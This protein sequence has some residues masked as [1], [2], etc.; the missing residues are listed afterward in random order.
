MNG[1]NKPT[2]AEQ[3][4]TEETPEPLPPPPPTF[5][6][7]TTAEPAGG[8]EEGFP[9]VY[10]SV[11][12]R[13]NPWVVYNQAEDD[14]INHEFWIGMQLTVLPPTPVEGG[15]GAEAPAQQPALTPEQRAL[16]STGSRRVLGT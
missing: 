1:E 7:R 15:A 9:R 5:G 2:Q 11:Y 16:R 4:K 3:P 12:E 14:M 6:F 8:W 13:Q 10:F